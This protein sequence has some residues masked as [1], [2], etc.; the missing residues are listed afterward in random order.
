M[1][2]GELSP[3]SN[4][5]MIVDDDEGF[6]RVLARFFELAGYIACAAT[7]LSQLRV[8]LKTFHADY[9]V[10]DLHLYRESGLDALELIRDH[11]PECIAV[12]LSGYIDVA[13]AGPQFEEAL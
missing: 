10:L 12:V 5:V 4:S 7:S 8:E 13:N 6:V 1:D 11:L 3:G 2:R 9:A